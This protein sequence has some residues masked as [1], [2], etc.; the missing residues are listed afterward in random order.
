MKTNWLSKLFR[1]RLSESQ[2]SLSLK[3]YEA[4]YPHVSLCQEMRGCAYNLFFLIGSESVDAIVRS[5]QT[6]S[7]DEFVFNGTKE[8]QDLSH[9][10]SILKVNLFPD[11]GGYIVHI[12]TNEEPLINCILQSNYAPPLPKVSFPDLNP[13]E[14]GALQGSLD[15][16]FQWLWL[17]YWLHIPASER[18]RLGLTVD[19]ME[20][21]EER[22]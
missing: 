10:G 6:Y 11:F 15:F 1:K 13:M 22:T 2:E 21:I 18:K 4:T 19:W 9:K 3:Q 8:P 12:V 7:D 14:Y 5:I 17:P 16:W 20:F